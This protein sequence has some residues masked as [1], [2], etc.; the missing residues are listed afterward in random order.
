LFQK[1]NLKNLNKILFH[2]IRGEFNMNTKEVCKKLNTT[3]KAL[4]IYEN[5]DIVVPKRDENSYRDYSKDD[6]LK[7]REVLLLKELD[8]SL[9]EI[10]SLTDKNIYAENQFA[11]SLYLQLRAIE[12]RINELD[13][14]KNTLKNSIDRMLE[15]DDELDYDDF[16]NNIAIILKEN[17]VNRKQ[18]IDRWGFNNR[19]VK[20]DEMVKDRSRDELGWFEKYD[21]ILGEIRK[22]I[23][24]YGA[25]S[26]LDIGC[27][28]GNL[29][30]ELSNRLDVIGIDQSLEML[31]QAK[32]KYND[33]ILRLGNFL[34]KPF[35][36]GKFDIVVTTY[37]FHALDNDEKKKALNNMLEY[38]KDKGKIIIVDFMFENEIERKNCQNRFTELGRQDL[39]DAINNR[40]YTNIEE[41]KNYVDTLDYKINFNHIV[42]FTW[43]V[44]IEK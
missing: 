41:L 36:K 19:A 17:K 34:D 11:R 2:F 27:G 3:P 33:M 25:K 6:L 40:Y 9:K 42:N 44:E 39:W 14:I 16:V 7:L 13:N 15:S 21:E 4:R 1:V 35:C 31:L 43:I 20:F 22:R 12:G 28:T 18:W 32:R 26:I 5:Y 30:G 37:A 24:D 23:I 8:F 38:L 10:K 29:C